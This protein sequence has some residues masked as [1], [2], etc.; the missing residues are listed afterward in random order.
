MNS[1]QSQKLAV[2]STVIA[3]TIK[4]IANIIHP[5]TSFVLLK[6]NFFIFMDENNT[7]YINDNLLFD[8]ICEKYVF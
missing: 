5:V 2:S 7:N 8:L 3:Y 1:P 6:F 4:D